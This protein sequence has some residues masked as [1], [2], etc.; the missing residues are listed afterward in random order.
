MATL[1]FSTKW[2][3]HMGDKRNGFV[4]KIWKGLIDSDLATEDEFNTY[5]I[6]CYKKNFPAGIF[7]LGIKGVIPKLHT[8][9][10]DEKDLWKPG[11]KIHPVVF[12]RTKNRF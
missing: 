5:D 1:G 12:N 11:R 6:E 7:P 9:R 2:P 8:I 4:S 10:Y 3:K